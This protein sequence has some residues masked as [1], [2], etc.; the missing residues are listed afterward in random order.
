MNNLF[1]SRHHK[2]RHYRRKEKKTLYAI[3]LIEKD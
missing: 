2:K 1:V 3:C